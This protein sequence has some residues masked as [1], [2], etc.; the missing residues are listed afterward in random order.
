M[1]A[2]KKKNIT[3]IGFLDFLYNEIVHDS[4]NNSADKQEL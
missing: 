1:M 2:N 4:Y 3:S